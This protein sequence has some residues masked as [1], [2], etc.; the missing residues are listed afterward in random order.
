MKTLTATAA[1]SETD[2]D[3]DAEHGVAEAAVELHSAVSLSEIVAAR[4]RI[5][6]S[7]ARTPCVESWPGALRSRRSGRGV[8]SFAR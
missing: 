8:S 6:G 7:V 5:N 1:E 3:A 4:L 2:A